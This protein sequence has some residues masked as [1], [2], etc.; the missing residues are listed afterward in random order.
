MAAFNNVGFFFLT[1]RRGWWVDLIWGLGVDQGAQ[2]IMADPE[3]EYEQKWGFVSVQLEVSRFQK[4]QEYNPN[5]GQTYVSYHCWVDNNTDMKT[6]FSI[7][8]G[9][10]A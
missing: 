10:N 8:G 5:T 1:G 7:Q 6:F 4:R 9:G 2:W 3:I